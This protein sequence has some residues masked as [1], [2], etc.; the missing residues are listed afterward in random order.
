MFCIVVFSLHPAIYALQ[1]PIALCSLGCSLL[2]KC[3]PAD[4]DPLNIRMAYL[5]ACGKDDCLS[6]NPGVAVLT[7]DSTGSR[8]FLATKQYTLIDFVS[9]GY[10]RLL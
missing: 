5:A 6:M 3:V 10:S 4:S 8:F 1:L 2:C 7:H 9:A